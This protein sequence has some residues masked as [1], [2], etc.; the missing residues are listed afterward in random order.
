MKFTLLPSLQSLWM[1][2]ALPFFALAGDRALAEDAKF[3]AQLIW[4][5]NDRKS[6]DPRH[7]AV[8]AEVRQKLARL[9]LKWAHYFEVNRKTFSAPIGGYARVAMSEKCSIEVK[10]LD[11]R[12]V[13]VLLYGRKNDVCT[14]QTQPLPKGEMLV[15]GGEAPN[16]TAWLVTLKRTE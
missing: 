14:K 13:E 11:A 10:V 16:A 6:P 1:A 8:E 7:K 3:E 4:A 5:S 12:R 9:P 2:L 15:L